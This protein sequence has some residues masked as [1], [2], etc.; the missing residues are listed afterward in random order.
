MGKKALAGGI[1]RSAT[2]CPGSSSGVTRAMNFRATESRLQYRLFSTQTPRGA[3][4][5][6]P[7]PGAI[8]SPVAY[9]DPLIGG[10]QCDLQCAGRSLETFSVSPHQ[11]GKVRQQQECERRIHQ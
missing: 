1:L 3:W 6:I 11:S 4:N 9:R 7:L 8:N 2:H 5:R 10:A